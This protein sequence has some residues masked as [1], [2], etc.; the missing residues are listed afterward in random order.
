MCELSTVEIVQ[1][2]TESMLIISYNDEAMSYLANIPSEYQEVE[3]IQSSW[4]QYIRSWFTPNNQSKAEFKVSNWTQGQW[5]YELF[6]ADRSRWNSGFSVLAWY[7]SFWSI[8]TSFSHWL[9]GNS[10]VHTWEFSQEWLYVDWVKKVTPSSQSFTSVELAIFALNRNWSISEYWSMRL[11][12]LKLYNNWTL[13]R[14]FYACY[15]KS[16]NVIW[17]YDKVNGVFYTNQGSWSFTKWP[18]YKRTD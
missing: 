6:W 10:S 15:R 16:D 17:L 8:A 3:Y 18:D 7:Y 14:D 12:Y 2:D 9:N 4:S 5:S 1:S 11:H 13:V